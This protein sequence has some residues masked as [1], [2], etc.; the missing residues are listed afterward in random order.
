MSAVRGSRGSAVCGC[1]ARVHACDSAVPDWARMGWRQG[2]R[3]VVAMVRCPWWAHVQVEPRLGDCGARL[4]QLSITCCFSADPFLPKL[5][6][7]AVDT[8]LVAD[9]ALTLCR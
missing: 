3:N 6:C 7:L 8:L 1:G 4:G 2:A 5:C 9:A